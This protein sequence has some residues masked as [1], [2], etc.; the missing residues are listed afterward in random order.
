MLSSLIEKDGEGEYKGFPDSSDGRVCLQCRRLRFDPWVGKIPL[1]KKIPW[2]EEPPGWRSP[3][4]C[5]ELDMT[6]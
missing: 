4:G 1:E 5:K 3:W 6:E 2:T